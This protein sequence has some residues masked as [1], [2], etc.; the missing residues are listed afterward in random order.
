MSIAPRPQTSPSTSSPPNGSCRQP[1]SLAGTTS[2]WPINSSDGGVGLPTLDARD[3][4]RPTGCGLV[5]LDVD[6]RAGQVG[7]EQIGA[8]HLAPGGRRAVVHARVADQVLQEVGDLGRDLRHRPHATA[9]SAEV[10]KTLWL[11]S[12]SNDHEPRRHRRLQ[13][14]HRGPRRPRAWPNS[15]RPSQAF[16]DEYSASRSSPSSSTPRSPTASPQGERKAYEEAVAANELI[17][18]PA[19]RHRPRRR[20][21]PADRP[22]GAGARSS[23]TTPSRSSTASTRGSSRRAASS[24]ASPCPTWAGC[25]WSGRRSGGRP[26]AGP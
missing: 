4:A 8:A 12:S 20:V 5:A 18:P 25:S 3:Q 22:P 14:R 19:G 9:G 2:V 17:T 16:I 23:P 6:A 15:T 13:H 26:A 21:R 10:T 11:N 7:L 24:A 1:A